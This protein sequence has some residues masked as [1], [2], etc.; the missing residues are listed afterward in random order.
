MSSEMVRRV[1]RMTK[2][3]AE[4]HR[5]LL[6]EIRGLSA[7]VEGSSSPASGDVARRLS[8]LA[9]RLERHMKDEEASE[10]YRWLPEYFS[11]LRGEAEALT[12]EH[13]ALL[14]EIRRL[15]EAA[16]HAERVTLDSEL[17]VAIRK[18]VAAIRDH[19]ARESELLGRAL[20]AVRRPA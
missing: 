1:R 11:E 14:A 15:S 9:Q 12:G 8:A 2:E 16:D 4:E 3:S 10:F 5:V 13:G 6:G 7:M 19:E 20:T 17:G 18:V